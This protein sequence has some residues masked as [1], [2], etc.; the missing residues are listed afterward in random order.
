MLTA[1]ERRRP[2]PNAWKTAPERLAELERLAKE[3]GAAEIAGDAGTLLE[4]LAE[5][6][7]YVACV[8]QFKRGKSTLLNALVGQP[9]LPAGVVP[10]TT[11]VTVV[12]YG[13]QVRARVR[14]GTEWL[15]ITPSEI[16]SYVSEEHN[17]ANE[18]RAGVVEV[19]VP[20]SLLASGMCLVDTPGIGS[21][22]TA[23]TE[24][25]KAFVP[26]ID[27]ALV[28]IGA[29]PPISGD[30]VA[31]IEEAAKHVHELIVVLNK[32]DRLTDA[33]RQQAIAFARK[34]LAQRLGKLIGPIFEVSA[35][36]RLTTGEA[37]RDWLGLEAALAT[38]AANTG[39]G[40]IRQ[41]E[42]RGSALL[43]QRLLHEITEQHDA[44]LRPVE[45]SERRITLLR[46]CVADAERALNDLGPLF[47]AEQKRLS[48]TFK[49]QWQRFV[50]DAVPAA[51]EE[52][53]AAMRQVGGRRRRVRRQAL[54][55][56]QDIATRWD[57][58][59]RGE[60]EP[61]AEQL[62][63]AA[64]QRF[65][66]VANGFLARRATSANALA[67]LPRSVN[68][69]VGFRTASRFHS[70]ELMHLTGRSPLQWFAG[71]VLPPA[72]A[73][74]RIEREMGAYLEHLVST[75]TARIL[76]DVGDRV[77]E[78]RRR[79][80]A[81]IRGYLR[82]VCGSAERALLGA[83]V[84]QAAGEQAVRSEV[85]RLDSIRQQVETICAE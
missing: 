79:L 72:M 50:K 18:K 32:A 22:I 19:F 33:E 69:E 52:F 53:S 1:D 76:N 73:R 23:N 38:L 28:V 77:L 40:L 24:A 30:E 31:L 7:F 82:E 37:A 67:E 64:A 55:L 25:T 66:E 29:D 71:I 10:I 43:A 65:V 45:E 78:S 27:A 16:A 46:T 70:T 17:P 44:L 48:A 63:R 47:A 54:Q 36:E 5:G 26:H 51:H 83:R 14:L 3:A 13:E 49:T 9:L 41:A 61:A 74:R 11:A 34:V 57:D 59:W 62:Y 2:Q 81:E 58:R 85:E 12:R 42:G 39:A 8:G 56:A 20:A 68:P 15:D 35:T 6:R 60:A 80:E 84:W 4:R 21:V 75:N